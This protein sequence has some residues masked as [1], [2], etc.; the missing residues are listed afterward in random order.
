MFV[1][2]SK[3]HDYIKSLVLCFSIMD[4]CLID[5][6]QTDPKYQP[7]NWHVL[8]CLHYRGDRRNACRRVILYFVV[9]RRE[10]KCLHFSVFSTTVTC[11]LASMKSVVL[12]IMANKRALIQHLWLMQHGCCVI[13]FTLLQ[14]MSW[15]SSRNRDLRRSDWNGT[16][17]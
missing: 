17:L 9:F 3:C 2:I 13:C 15:S 14:L 16:I 5:C 1:G 12:L 7:S 11:M 10:E 4:V 6:L 8:N